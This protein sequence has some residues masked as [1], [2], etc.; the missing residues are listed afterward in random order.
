MNILDQSRAQGIGNDIPSH[1]LDIGILA[2]GMII[3]SLLEYGPANFSAGQGFQRSHSLA[4]ITDRSQLHHPMHMIRHNNKTQG[5][6][7]TTP[8]VLH[9]YLDQMPCGAEIGEHGLPFSGDR[10]DDINLVG[11]GTTSQSQMGTMGRLLFGH[12]KNWC[13]GI[14][15]GAGLLRVWL[16]MGMG[17]CCQGSCLLL[18]SFC[19]GVCP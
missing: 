15:R 12:E 10:G 17:R 9:H 5:V 7:D 13:V 11:D 1:C 4:E 16:F 14:A 18:T 6:R 3:K 2:Q 19:C 8:L